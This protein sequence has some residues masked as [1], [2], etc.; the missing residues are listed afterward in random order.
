MEGTNLHNSTAVLRIHGD[1]GAEMVK[2]INAVAPSINGTANAIH[3]NDISSAQP[4]YS[5]SDH[6]LRNNQEVR[7]MYLAFG[8]PLYKA[9][10]KGEWEIANAI[11]T[12]DPRLL[13]AS[14]CKGGQNV[15]HFAAGTKH[16]HFVEKLV[17][18]MTE[19]ELELTDKKGNTAFC[20]AV[21]TGAVQVATIML[22]K[23]PR[24]ATIRGG[25]NERVTPLYLAAIF[26]RS[27]MAWCLYPKTQES[28]EEKD[29]IGIFF[30]CIGTSIYDLAI[31]MLQDEPTLAVARDKDNKTALHLLASTPSAF[32]NQSST[33]WSK[34][35]KSCFNIGFERNLKQS[36]ALELVKCLWGHALD[37]G[38]DKVMDLISYPSELL[39]DA[40][41]CGN[42]EFLAALIS[43]YPDLLWEVDKENRSIIHIAVLY[44]HANIYNLIHEIG[45]IK[46]LLA[47]YDD[48]QNNNLLHLAA[49]LPPPE[50]LNTVSGPALQMQKELLWFE[51]VKKIVQ[52][53]YM[54]AKNKQGECPEELFCKEHKRLLREGETWMKH[55]ANSCML[56]ATLIATVVFAAAF[57]LPGGNNDKGSPNDLAS[58]S[59]LIFVL[60]D[61]LALLNSIVSMV[62]FLSILI[63]RYTEY[64]FLIRLPLK[65]I[66]GL[67]SLFFSMITMMISFSLAFVIAY[68]HGIKWVPLLISMLAIVPIALFAILKFP[69]VLDT[70]SSTYC[71]G[72]LFQPRHM[73]N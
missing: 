27:E 62:M 37:D 14:I 24:L 9:A 7:R 47:T 17:E 60:S 3:I 20:S 71:S 29:R 32:D 25:G 6:L 15:L 30:S 73:L 42:F 66:I 61:G 22:L 12:K 18:V 45:S 67:T 36:K 26:G 19:E 31:E 54:K 63:S 65:L 44:R 2:R 13:T 56:V 39:F 48:D 70:F 52:P 50:R 1:E 51:E 34:L 5:S 8:V 49:R 33:G 21:A 57:S 41:K 46:D 58:T 35:I 72:T 11:L 40:T 43:S 59:F 38:D 28:L 23:N 16:V 10:L 68:D 69:L 4:R 64:D 53:S 55:T